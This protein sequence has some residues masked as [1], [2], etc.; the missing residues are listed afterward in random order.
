DAVRLVVERDLARDRRLERLD[1]HFARVGIILDDVDLLAAELADDRLH[2]GAAR[3]D[4]R[5]HRIHFRIGADHG[6]LRAVTGL[7]REGLDF[8]RAIGDLGHLE[9]EQAA[10]ELRA[11]PAQNDLG[12]TRC[13]LDFH[14]DATDALPRLVFFAGDLFLAR[15]DGFRLAEVDEQVVALAAPHGAGDDVAHLVLEVV[16]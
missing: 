10:N 3:A 9:L 5:P 16:V 6:D 13:A 1:D 15:H 11:R 14:Q 4:A 12:T 2:P 7:A 8:H